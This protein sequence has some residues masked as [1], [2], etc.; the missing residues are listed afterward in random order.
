MFERKVTVH[1]HIRGSVNNNKK[2]KWK[3]YGGKLRRE[4]YNGK[5]IAGRL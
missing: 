3:N 5:T 1:S 4:D 2:C